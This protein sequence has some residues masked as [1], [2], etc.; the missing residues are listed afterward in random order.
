LTAISFE[1]TKGKKAAAMAT[2]V[3]GLIMT[4]NH[5]E[6]T[7]AMESQPQ[8]LRSLWHGKSPFLTWDLDPGD[9]GCIPPAREVIPEHLAISMEVDDNR[10]VPN[11]PKGTWI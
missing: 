9:S 6:S 10:A 5:T 4:G 1:Y 2:A 7:V 8:T 3:F 11:G